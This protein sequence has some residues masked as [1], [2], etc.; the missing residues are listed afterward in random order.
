MAKPRPVPAGLL[1]TIGSADYNQCNQM[2][3]DPLRKSPARNPLLPNRKLIRSGTSLAALGCRARPPR[4]MRCENNS[5]P[6]R[7]PPSRFPGL[8][9]LGRIMVPGSVCRRST[10]ATVLP[11]GRIRVPFYPS[12]SAQRKTFTQINAAY[13][14]IVPQFVRGSRTK[15]TPFGDDVGPVRHA[16]RL[17]HIV[18]RNQDPDAAGL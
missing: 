17:T 2:M 11:T 8:T 18:I 6:A 7:Y 10:A 4:T 14:Y 1:M 16:Q 12:L 5:G 3:D 9:F 13:L 15:Y